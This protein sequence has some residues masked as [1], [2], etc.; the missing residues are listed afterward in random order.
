MGSGVSR[1]VTASSP[2][3][4]M[5]KA[6]EAWKSLCIG[7]GKLPQQ[8][9][10]G[11][12]REQVSYQLEHEDGERPLIYSSSSRGHPMSE[13]FATDARCGVFGVVRQG[14]GSSGAP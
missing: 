9:G 11:K 7:Y 3:H 13:P 1:T 6:C 5:L 14:N 12:I 8:R 4:E 2:K 10:R